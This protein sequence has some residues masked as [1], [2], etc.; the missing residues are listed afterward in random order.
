MPTVAMINGHAFAGGIMLAM[1]HDYRVQSPTKGFLC[2]N[3]LLLGI[4]LKP[5][6]SS[7]FRQKLSP[8][9]YRMMVLEAKRFSG[10]EALEGGVVD[11]LGGM[12][13]LVR[14]IGERGVGVGLAMLVMLNR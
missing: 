13:E 9:T 2:L 7:I 14:F 3:E 12:E 4:P 6:M 1:Y 10:K 8:Q 11:C 5:A